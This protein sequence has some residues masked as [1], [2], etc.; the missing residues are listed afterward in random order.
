MPD[1][2][3]LR[4]ESLWDHILQPIRDNDGEDEMLSIARKNAHD[5]AIT[6][7]QERLT[8]LLEEVPKQ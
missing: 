4:Y 5:S 7:Q 8:R 1:Y 2:P 3:A 6:E